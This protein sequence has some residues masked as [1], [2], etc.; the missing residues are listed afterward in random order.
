MILVAKAEPKVDAVNLQRQPFIAPPLSV[1]LELDLLLRLF[2]RHLAVIGIRHGGHEVF[3]VAEDVV[4]R[5]L[6]QRRGAVARHD[7]VNV[8][9]AQLLQR[10]NDVLRIGI[11]QAAVRQ[12]ARR[13]EVDGK[14]Q[15][16]LG[17]VQDGHAVGMVR[18]EVEKP[19]RLPAKTDGVVRRVGAVRYDHLRVGAVLEPRQAV[20]LTDETGA[21]L[22]ENLSAGRMVPMRVAVDDVF[23]RRLRDLADFRHQLFRRRRAD[24]IGNDHPRRRHDEEIAMEESAKAV[25]SRRDLGDFIRFHPRRELSP[26]RGKEQPEDGCQ[27]YQQSRPPYA[28]PA[29]S[30]PAVVSHR[31]PLLMMVSSPS[32]HPNS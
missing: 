10:R 15:A 24:G 20:G 18:T 12:A 23:D 16:L 13:E 25:N 9:V 28:R 26:G 27:D 32:E 21:G 1:L 14:G 2:Q 29:Y 3:P 4:D 30:P 22:F 31:S 11:I 5:R 19:N 7:A 6:G 8:E 17:Q